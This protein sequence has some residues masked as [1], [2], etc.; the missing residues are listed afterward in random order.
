MT[1][2][3]DGE[4]V[5]LASAS[6]PRHARQ[7]ARHRRRPR[8][9]GLAGKGMLATA[10]VALLIAV[11]AATAAPEHPVALVRR[12]QHQGTVP[13][14]VLGA[15][16]GVVPAVPLPQLPLP[17]LPPMATGSTPVPVSITTVGTGG[18]V[19]VSYVDGI[20]SIVLAAYQAAA[21]N[22]A[23]SQPGCHLPVALLAAIGKVESGHARGGRV[24]ANGTALPPILG[25]VLD[26]SDGFAAVP[27]TDHGALDGDPTWDRAVGPMQ[28]LPSTWQRWG[29]DGNHDGIEDPENVWDA[30]LAAARYLCA[31]DRDLATDSGVAAAILSYNHS[32][33][34]LRL[35]SAWLTAYRG[36]IVE[37]ADVTP[38]SV[39]TAASGATSAP[40][41][42]TTVP[43]T[44]TSPPP[45]PPVP[46]A[47]ATTDQPAPPP[48]TPIPTLINPVPTSTTTPAP[49][50]VAPQQPVQ[51]L[52]CGLQNTLTG[53]GGLLGLAPPQQ[54]CDTE[55][56]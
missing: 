20:P 17:P 52:L 14:V 42:A 9:T 44:P 35:V 30:S 11:S 37:I 12:S 31:D 43:S 46:T 7:R 39:D 51:G 32:A 45:T 15:D 16:G 27:D 25:P 54:P 49:Q 34:Y 19:A 55:S 41:P 24:T 40:Q 5:G 2:G 48:I 36:G 8:G 22:L 1:G 13:P 6:G 21:T 56:P 50:P 47:P 3:T 23:R 28:F 4:V 33:A 29:S 18:A 53:L 38:T 26:G 10:G